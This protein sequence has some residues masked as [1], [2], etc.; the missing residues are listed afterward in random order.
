MTPSDLKSAFGA[1]P[2][3]VKDCV[4]RSLRMEERSEPIMKKKLS[5]SLIAA[6]LAMLL[7]AGA[8]LAAAQSGRLAEWLGV[9]NEKTG[10][11]ETDA[12]VADAIQYLNQSVEGNAL[13][14]TVTEALYD[15]EG[16][17]YSLA[18]RYEPLA[19]GDPLYVVCEGPLFDGE[20]THSMM[21]M[22]DLECYLTGPMDC[23]KS[24]HLPEN[25]CA[26]ATLSLNVYRVKGEIEHKGVDDFVKPGMTD[27]EAEK[28]YEEW[29]REIAADGKL[30]MAGDG[31]LEPLWWDVKPD[32]AQE[33]SLVRAGLLERVDQLTLDV[34]IGAVRL[35][36]VK[37]L[38]TPA[39]FALEGGGTLRV[40]SCTVTPMVAD[41]TAEYITVERPAPSDMENGVYIFASNPNEPQGYGCSSSI[42]DPIQTADGCWSMACHIVA[43]PLRG[44][45]DA[46]ELKIVHYEN[47]QDE[48][49]GT[50]T[51]ELI[52]AAE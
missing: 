7:L 20:W 50:A 41:I 4:A 11:I 23:A 8:A 49:I 35:A 21:S 26:V 1:T 25:G 32:E 5:L 10:E 44:A 13:R 12:V 28:A 3:R 27:E 37:T 2:Q 9:Y 17:T 34:D 52:D 24:G 33:E 38:A 45:P 48:I 6:A 40:T 29:L 39:E 43:S 22:N 47:G 18:W 36:T 42:G 15:P 16:G 14:C 31:V 30:N 46:I 19:E 51:I